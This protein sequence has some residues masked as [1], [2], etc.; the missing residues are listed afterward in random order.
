MMPRVTLR[1]GS[2]EFRCPGCGWTHM[3]NTDPAQ[4]P[5][6]VFNGDAR[7]PTLSP[8]INATRTYTAADRAD[9]RCH[10]F[11]TDGRIGF[12]DDCTHALAGQTIDLPEVAA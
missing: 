2:V 11:V 9:E 6:W 5:C 4:S 10:A 8:S 3:L 12:L 7:F 1:A